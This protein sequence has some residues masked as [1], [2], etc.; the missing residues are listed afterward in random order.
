M[1]ADNLLI[2]EDQNDQ[3]EQESAQEARAQ[4]SNTYN[5]HRYNLRER[6]TSWKERFVGITVGNLSVRRSLRE[7]GTE[8]MVSMM[9]EMHQMH[10]KGVFEPLEYESL[11]SNQ[12]RKIIRSLMFTKRKRDGRLKSRFCADGR[13]Q[14]VSANEDVSSP[15]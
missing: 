15:T 7:L 3:E 8:A 5:Q 2:S 13:G 14:I 9:K 4:L 6:R 10:T 1:N 12:R 11:S